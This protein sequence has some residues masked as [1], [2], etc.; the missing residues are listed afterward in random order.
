[1]HKHDAIPRDLL[2]IS[3]T[4]L[5]CLKPISYENKYQACEPP[6]VLLDDMNIV[7]G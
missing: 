1:M 2:V 7:N 5:H 3:S 4:F 6:L